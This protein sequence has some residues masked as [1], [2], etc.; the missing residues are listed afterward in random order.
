[1]NGANCHEGN[2]YKLVAYRSPANTLR[3]MAPP[4]RRKF[5]GI[6]GALWPTLITLLT[7]VA[8]ILGSIYTQDIKQAFPFVVIS[9]DQPWQWSW[10]A[11][12][13]WVAGLGASV[14]FFLR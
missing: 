6:S 7:L 2:S 8:G 10:R 1:M 3:H 5:L 14:C 9:W 11:S 13:F 12:S 4:K